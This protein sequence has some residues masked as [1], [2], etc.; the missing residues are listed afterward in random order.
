MLRSLAEVNRK[1]VA[2]IVLYKLR[3]ATEE[4]QSKISAEDLLPASGDW[5]HSISD[6]YTYC[7][8]GETTLEDLATT[9]SRTLVARA[10]SSLKNRYLHLRRS[11]QDLARLDSSLSLR[12]ALVLMLFNYKS[13]LCLIFV[14]E[15]VKLSLYKRVLQYLRKIASPSAKLLRV[16]SQVVGLTHKHMLK[17]ISEAS[18]LG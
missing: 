10:Y 15:Y 4:S 9:Y 14:D 6:E 1:V 2:L 16:A 7:F 13:H 11:E 5:Q 17:A 12:T 8:D 18:L 3:P